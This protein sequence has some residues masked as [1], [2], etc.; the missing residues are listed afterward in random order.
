MSYVNLLFVAFVFFVCVLFSF[1]YL[2]L[3]LLYSLLLSP[4]LFAQHLNKQEPPPPRIIIII[5]VNNF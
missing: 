2:C 3:C 4:W 5:N 1:V